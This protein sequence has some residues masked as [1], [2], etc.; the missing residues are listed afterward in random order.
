LTFLCST[1]GNSL[2][3]ASAD[4]LEGA[5]FPQ[6]LSDQMLPD[7]KEIIIMS[8]MECSGD[9]CGA[10]RPGTVAYRECLLLYILEG[11]ELYSNGSE[12]TASMAPTSSSSL[13]ST[14]P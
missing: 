14:C 1:F 12:Q 8:D 4:G 2:S 10:V 3:Y 7:N 13:N 9:S 11:E 5:A 6:I